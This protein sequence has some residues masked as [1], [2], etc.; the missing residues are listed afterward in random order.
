MKK[1][2]NVL[3]GTS[4]IENIV[5]DL[6]EGTPPMDI[7]EIIKEP[8]VNSKDEDAFGDDEKVIMPAKKGWPSSTNITGGGGIWSGKVTASKITG[9]SNP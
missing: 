6:Y 9:R 2:E 5:K 4:Q 3:L 8:L 7:S 1:Y